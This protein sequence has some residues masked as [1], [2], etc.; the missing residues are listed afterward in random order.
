MG[1][2]AKRTG[3]AH[4]KYEATWAGG[5]GEGSEES[6]GPEELAAQH[7]TEGEEG[8]IEIA[9]HHFSIS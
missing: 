9:P 4:G 2:C 8:W 6:G 3:S 1:G 5:A 7:A